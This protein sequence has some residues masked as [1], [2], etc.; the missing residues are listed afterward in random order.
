MKQ[1]G[2]AVLAPYAPEQLRLAFRVLREA[3]S[4]GIQKQEGL[5]GAALH[6]LRLAQLDA[7]ATGTSLF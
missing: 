6:T 3:L 7:A 2:G 1:I 4:D 5:R